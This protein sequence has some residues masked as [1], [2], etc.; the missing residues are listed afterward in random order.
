[1]KRE[2][3]L[4]AEALPLSIKKKVNVWATPKTIFRIVQELK[5]KFDPK[6]S[7]SRTFRLEGI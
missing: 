5:E 2:E 1:V 7:Q 6:V 4:V 3:T